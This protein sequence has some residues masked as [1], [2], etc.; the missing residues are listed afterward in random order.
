VG[1]F[2]QLQVKPGLL[3][4]EAKSVDSLPEGEGWQ[5]EP[6]WDGFRCIVFRD[7]DR[8][9]LQSKSGKPLA[10][11][12]PE[13]VEALEALRAPRLAL[14]GE[15]II[16]IGGVLSFDALQ[17]RLHPAESRIRKLA[18]QTPAQLMLFD[19]LADPQ[20]KSLVERPLSERREALERFFTKEAA[21]ALQLSAFTQDRELAQSWLDTAGGALDAST[22]AG[23]GGALRSCH[24]QPLP[25]R[26]EVPALAA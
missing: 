3:P 19:C 8:I 10:R 11:Y 5:Y 7:G 18:A 4:M 23:R 13:M 9:E 25:P 26:H 22:G 17:M 6:K 21:P 20:G 1:D 2:D 12:F 14:D 16:P 24:R 15:L